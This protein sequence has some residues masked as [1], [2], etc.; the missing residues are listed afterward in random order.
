MTV[1]PGKSGPARSPLGPP[2]PP[3]LEQNLWGI[4]G[5]GFYGAIDVLPA[6]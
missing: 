3:I 2:P 4:S 5:M 6:T 1:I